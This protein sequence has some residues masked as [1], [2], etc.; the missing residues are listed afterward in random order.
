MTTGTKIGTGAVTRSTTHL[1][2]KGRI[3]INDIQ[4]Q[5]VQCEDELVCQIREKQG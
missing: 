2:V 1:T 3:N 5:K 4:I